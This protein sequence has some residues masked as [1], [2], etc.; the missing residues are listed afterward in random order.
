MAHEI[1]LEQATERAHQAEIV[2]RLLGAHPDAL[3]YGEVIA[4]AS[5]LARL[6]GN[7]TTWMMEEKH[8]REESHA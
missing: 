2:C 5:L 1:T 8:L 6:T 7:V 3:S 4:I